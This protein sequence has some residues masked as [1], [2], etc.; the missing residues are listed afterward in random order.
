MGLGC[1][2]EV[3]PSKCWLIE[4]W[5]KRLVLPSCRGA[6]GL[7]RKSELRGCT[8]AFFLRRW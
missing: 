1:V 3:S 8:D 4:R 5:L 7:P 2:Q 6:D